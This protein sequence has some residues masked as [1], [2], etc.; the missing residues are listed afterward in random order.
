M[1]IFSRVDKFNLKF[2]IDQCPFH[3]HVGQD[4]ALRNHEITSLIL[5]YKWNLCLLDY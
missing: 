4:I 2:G 3:R 5:Y 1:E